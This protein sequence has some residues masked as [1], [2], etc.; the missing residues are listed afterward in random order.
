MR[1]KYGVGKRIGMIIL[2]ATLF[3]A[4]PPVS[5][6][7]EETAS[8]PASESATQSQPQ[9]TEKQTETETTTQ[10]QTQ[11][12]E[13]ETEADN[14]KEASL[15]GKDANI[16]MFPE[17][18]REALYALKAKHP[19]WKFVPY[20]TRL[21]WK[22]LIEL[23]NTNKYSL[24]PSYFPEAMIV[25]GTA[26][27]TGWAVAT[28]YAIEYYMDPR[29]WLTEEYI[30]QFEKLTFNEEYHTFAA[31]ANILK[32]SFMSGLI[33][34]YNDLTYAQAFFNIGRYFSVS[35]LHL[36]SR[37]YQEQGKN[38]KSDL[39]SGTYPGYEGYYNYFNI[40]A[41]GSTKEAIIKN[42]LQEAKDE[43]WDE[44]YKALLG[45]SEKVA[46]R[47]A[48]KGQVNVYLQKFDIVGI[49]AGKLPSQYMQNLAA[50]SNE[51]LRIMK[52][53]LNMDSM[54]SDFE[55]YI[56]VYEG[57]PRE[58]G[59]C[60]SEDD[61]IL[62]SVDQDMAQIGGVWTL[63]YELGSC[64]NVTL[65]GFG[66]AWTY[67]I[68]NKNVKLDTLN[69]NAYQMWEILNAGEQANGL[70][71]VRAN[72]DHL[73][74]IYRDG[75]IF[76][77]TENDNPLYTFVKTDAKGLVQVGDDWYYFV[78]GIVQRGFNG[79]VENE[80]GFWYVEDGK[81]RFDYC[82]LAENEHGTWYIS[83]GRVSFE[84]TGL[85]EKDGEK[86]LIY[87]GMY[88]NEYTGMFEV[89]KKL[90]F[91]TNGKVDK[92]CTG[93]IEYLGEWYAIIYGE[94]CYDYCG[95]VENEYGWWYV[96]DGKIDFGY[97][98]LAANEYGW[99]AI[100]GGRID[101]E[102]TGLMQNEYGWW[103]VKNGSIDFGYTGLVQNEAGW[104]T[105]FLGKVDFGYT[106]IAENE[107]GKWYA[108][109]GAIRFDY[110]GEYIAD[111]IHYSIQNGLVVGWY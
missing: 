2:A 101:F 98:G 83:N 22:T 19:S 64:Y 13:N 48:D 63:G 84:Y 68:N 86:C 45:G 11:G 4:N 81:V 23:E 66:K 54:D 60:L 77:G 44:R 49:A 88:A 91:F 3:G 40:K 20:N 47:I 15:D 92:S 59:H 103:Y 41:S 52:T 38:G 82:G 87:Q 29:N 14:N 6:Y 72:I 37:V 69:S 74:I 67:D 50:P 42:G 34:G 21:D 79:L 58:V 102:Y 109:G 108:E 110:T 25:K 17:S 105:V 8:A 76:I 90:Y 89:D 12:T 51:G 43:G 31:V 26:D 27:A 62:Y 65:K 94:V 18:Y 36:A 39:I 85:F 35:P 96:H 16:E 57:M 71:K 24:L 100:S 78:D 33:E 97:S 28:P 53:Y 30:F 1:K 73:P 46:K 70:Y 61:Y 95:I 56:P 7:A 80:A 93:L 10:S 107:L 75:A 55:F 111:G 106:G 104:W 32:Y 9:D 99:W 5:I